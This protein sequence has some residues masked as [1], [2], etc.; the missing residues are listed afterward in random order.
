MAAGIPSPSNAYRGQVPPAYQRAIARYGQL[1]DR[2]ARKWGL[3][4]EQLLAKLLAG[5]SGFRMNAVSSANARGAAQFIP[6]TRQLF[7]QRYGV[8]PW[9]DI[10]S[11]V[12]GAALYMRDQGLKA[13]NP[14]GGQA[15]IRYILAQQP[16]GVA[17]GLPGPPLLDPLGPL[18]GDR[19]LPGLNLLT[20]ELKQGAT[21]ALLY[22]L[23]IGAGA[24]LATYGIYKSATGTDTGA[25]AKQLATDAA[26]AAATRGRGAK[27]AA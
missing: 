8:D 19:G 2:E 27:A 16:R 12:K 26:L 25:Q 6:S 4:G 11:A 5:E 22:A 15:Y 14:G 1:A 10:D 3:T 7:I 21:R 23:L 24:W 18:D 9:R 13:Y 20:D 17:A